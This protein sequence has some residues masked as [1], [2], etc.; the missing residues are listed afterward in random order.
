[1]HP[2]T[3]R[4]VRNGMFAAITIVAFAAVVVAV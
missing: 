3:R 2:D 4:R 1:M